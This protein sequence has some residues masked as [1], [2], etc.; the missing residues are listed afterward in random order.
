MLY[1]LVF[2]L[3]VF[4][5]DLVLYVRTDKLVIA[6]SDCRVSGFLFSCLHC[7]VQFPLHIFVCVKK[8]CLLSLRQYSTRNLRLHLTF[9]LPVIYAHTAYTLARVR[10]S[11]SLTALHIAPDKV[12]AICDCY[13]CSERDFTLTLTRMLSRY[14]CIALCNCIFIVLS[15]QSF[16]IEYP[17]FATLRFIV[18]K[19]LNEHTNPQMIS[20]ALRHPEEPHFDVHST[21]NNFLL[22]VQVF[23]FLRTVCNN[24]EMVNIER[25]PSAP[26][27]KAL[28]CL[29]DL[30]I[31]RIFSI[32][33]KHGIS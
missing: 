10:C 6:H 2:L 1:A 23:F 26:K 20:D 7:S 11:K 5:I 28:Q 14:L 18:H 32:C 31:F 21:K 12:P 33:R 4:F 19:T 9:V 27:L 24:T 8:K 30:V 15:R 16:F 22:S 3:S 17:R 29:V 13:W 25:F